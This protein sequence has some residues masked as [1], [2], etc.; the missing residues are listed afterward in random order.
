MTRVECS[1]PPRSIGETRSWAPATTR[2][3]VDLPRWQPLADLDQFQSTRVGYSQLI[4]ALVGNAGMA[5]QRKPCVTIF[6]M[7]NAET[8]CSA[9]KSL[10]QQQANS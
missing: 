5:A 7:H 9:R 8:E 3:R 10:Q 1:E 4:D 2:L 6:C